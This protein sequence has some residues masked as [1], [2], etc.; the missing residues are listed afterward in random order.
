MKKQV[1]EKFYQGNIKRIY[2]YVFFRVGQNHSVAEDLVS[3]IF[4][5][6]LK[7]YEGYDEKV[8][9]SAWIYRI[10]HNHVIN[11]YRDKKE[12]ID[13]DSVELF[14]VDTK[15]S[16]EKGRFEARDDLAKAFQVLSPEE[17]RFVTMKHVDGY[18]YIEMVEMTGK[19]A[20][21]LKMTVSRAM[22]KL[23]T[24]AKDQETT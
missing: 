18:K 8:S 22:K 20:G 2:R 19:S 3:E 9:R 24:Y 10:A 23:K 16:S 12:T 1:F 4:M 7:A 11:H 6:A 5:K 14:L 13:F 17:Q 15:T 21:A